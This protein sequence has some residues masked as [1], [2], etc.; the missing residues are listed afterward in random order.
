MEEMLRKKRIESIDFLRGLVMV[1]MVLDHVRDFFHA[2]A[3]LYDPTDV[4]QTTPI[5]FFTR[6][7]T[8]FCAPVFVFLA[9]TSAFFVGTRLTKPELSKWLLKRGIW[10][11]IVEL[12]IMKFGWAFKLD[13]STSVLQVIWALGVSMIFLALFIHLPKRMMITLSL[14]AVF[15]HNLVDNFQPDNFSTLWAILHVMRPINIFGASFFAAYPLIP[16]IF[17]MCLG[18]HFGALYKSDFSAPKRAKIILGIGLACVVL[19]VIMRAFNNFGEP[20][21]WSTQESLIYTFLS[22]FEVSKYPPSLLYLL[23]TL[24]PSL[25]LLAVSEKW[26]GKFHQAL[27]VIG[28]VPMFYYI[29][30]V[31]V[32]HVLAVFGAMISG[33]PASSMIIDLFVTLTPEL[34]GYGFNLGVVY[35]IWFALVVAMY[36][37]CRW[38]N[39][40]KTSNRD[41]WWLSYL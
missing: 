29:L 1:I 38:Y 40:Y 10:L 15:G 39:E 41:K 13:Y 6:F 24:G 34:K 26:R 30:H 7:I 25:I 37:M 21:P 18:Y 31:Y 14:V 19:F 32:I 4:T 12:T 22:F 20:K 2:D 36:P 9:G 16:W 8:H 23:I 35:G 33:Y 11:I 5:L 3:F 28:R 27:V 17:V